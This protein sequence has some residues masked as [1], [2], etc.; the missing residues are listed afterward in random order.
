MNSGKVYHTLINK[1]NNDLI[2]IIQNYN[3]NYEQIN[4]F[5]ELEYKIWKL[6]YYEYSKFRTKIIH[7]KK[8]KIWYYRTDYPDIFC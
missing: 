5:Q 6:S 1:L 8:F 7:S 3:I 4:Y 2:R